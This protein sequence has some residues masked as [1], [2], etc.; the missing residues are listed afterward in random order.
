MDTGR[1]VWDSGASIVLGLWLMIAP[2]VFGYGFVGPAVWNGMV[3]GTLIVMVAA[4]KA[5]GQYRVPAVSWLNVI[6]G[7]WLVVAPLVLDY[8]AAPPLLWNAIIVGLL[9]I[10][11]S[12]RSATAGG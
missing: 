12:W 9:L 3:V 4:A 8:A 7:V 11:L 10:V 6:L 2:V 5:V 1:V